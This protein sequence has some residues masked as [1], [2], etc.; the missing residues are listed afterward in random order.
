MNEP[1]P[2]RTLSEQDAHQLLQNGHHLGWLFERHAPLEI[3]SNGAINDWRA[4]SSAILRRTHFA[5]VSVL[6]MPTREPDASVLTRVLYEHVVTFCWVAIDPPTRLPMLIRTEISAVRA[7]MNELNDAGAYEKEAK[8]THAV[9]AELET[10]AAPT[11]TRMPSVFACAH[12]AEAHWQGKLPISLRLAR[13][14]SNLYRPYSAAV[15]PRIMGLKSFVSGANGKLTFGYP[16]TD[17]PEA[18][19]AAVSAFQDGLLVA[20]TCLGWPPVEEVVRAFADG[21]SPSD[22]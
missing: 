8:E 6:G 1:R 7:V 15:H 3:D 10:L 11:G 4:F 12:E 17:Y 14:Y 19:L 18:A 21:L 5:L 22:P 13:E 2:R 9:L 20:G 16:V